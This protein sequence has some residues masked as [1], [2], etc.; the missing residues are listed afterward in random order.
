MPQVLEANPLAKRLRA[1]RRRLRFV[2]GLRGGACLVAMAVLGITAA[3]LLDYGI[4]LPGLVRAFFLVS[5]VVGA[6][7][8][9]YRYLIRPLRTRTDDLSLALRIEAEY[10]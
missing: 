9:T 2:V 5:V 4:H 7:A 8:I 1:L 10:P 3:S 6:G